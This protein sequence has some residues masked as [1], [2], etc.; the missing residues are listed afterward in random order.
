LKH[1][2]HEGTNDTNFVRKDKSLIREIRLFVPFVI[3]NL[4]EGGYSPCQVL[5]VKKPSRKLSGT[6]NWPET[7]LKSAVHTRRRIF[8]A[9][10][11]V[12][13]TQEGDYP[14]ERE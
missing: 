14:K 5:L 8:G 4:C 12:N 2:C 11:K 9:F 13:N 3:P 6:M 7:R 10:G 1:E